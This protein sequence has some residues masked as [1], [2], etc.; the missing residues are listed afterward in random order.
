MP[1]G[2]ACFFFQMTEKYESNIS[3]DM[4]YQSTKMVIKAADDFLEPTDEISLSLVC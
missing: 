1:P 2:M 4:K 3:T